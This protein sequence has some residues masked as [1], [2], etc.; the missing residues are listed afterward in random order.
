MTESKFTPRTRSLSLILLDV[1]LRNMEISLDEI[2]LIV[3]VIIMVV[4]KVTN[5]NSFR[6]TLEKIRVP[7]LK[8]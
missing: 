3:G 2:E 4:T 7:V 6:S 8:S 1:C 5:L